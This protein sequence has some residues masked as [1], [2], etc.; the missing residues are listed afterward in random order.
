VSLHDLTTTFAA[1]NIDWSGTRKDVAQRFRPA[2]REMRRG[3]Y[4]QY[5]ENH[6]TAPVYDKNREWSKGGAGRLVIHADGASLKPG[7]FKIGLI[8]RRYQDAEHLHR[9]RGEVYGATYADCLRLV[10]VLDMSGHGGG[11]DVVREGERIL[12]RK[13]DAFID[14]RMALHPEATR[15]GDWRCL[16]DRLPVEEVATH[17]RAALRET[18]TELGLRG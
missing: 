11:D 18:A 4:V 16:R 13:V 9:A 5:L 3:L 7:K 15:Q 8:T 17:M 1:T 6:G 2:L 14:D 12:K 10:L